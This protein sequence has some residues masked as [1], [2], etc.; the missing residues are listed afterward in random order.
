[1]PFEIDLKKAAAFLD[2]KENR[3]LALVHDRFEKATADCAAIVEMIKQKFK[4]ERIY[5]WGS[6][7]DES[8]FSEISD[9]D[10]AVEGTF[11]AEG[12][13]RMLEAAEKLTDFPVDLVDINKIDPLHAES[14]RFKG[15]K[16]YE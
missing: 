13:F 1:M 11:S 5:Q 7:L 10:I 15:R 4:P 2:E 3:R 6:L 8:K 12:M 14:I 16:V 9:I